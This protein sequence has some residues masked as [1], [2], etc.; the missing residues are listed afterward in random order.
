MFTRVMM[1]IINIPITVNRSTNLPFVMQ[2]NTEGLSLNFGSNT[3][4]I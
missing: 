1:I 4:Q 3:K 2:K